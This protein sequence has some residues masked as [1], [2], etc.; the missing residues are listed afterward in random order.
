MRSEIVGIYV[1]TKSVFPEYVAEYY[2][3]EHK[4]NDKWWNSRAIIYKQFFVYVFEKK[5]LPIIYET[6][7]WYLQNIHIKY[8]AIDK[9][10]EFFGLIWEKRKTNRSFM[11]WIFV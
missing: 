11:N 1:G 2:T 3:S 7:F 10:N 8:K 4:K 5:I 9:P 6:S